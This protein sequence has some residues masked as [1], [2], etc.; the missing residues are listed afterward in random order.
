MLRP[1]PN[2]YYG[3]LPENLWPDRPREFYSYTLNVIPLAAGATINADVVFSKKTDSLIFGGAVIRTTPAGDS[4]FNPRSGTFVRALVQLSN[5]AS[6]ELFTDR[7]DP[8]NGL[9]VPIENLFAAWGPIMPGHGF[10]NAGA[11]LPVFWPIPIY[12]PKGGALSLKL[13]DLAAT[14]SHFRFT[15]WGGLIYQLDQREVA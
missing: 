14:A 2:W 15:F 6:N 8:F 4:I 3:L 1:L 11:R 7:S 9:G 13:S 10:V 5:S 12:V